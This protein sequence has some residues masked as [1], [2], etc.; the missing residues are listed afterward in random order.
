[1]EKPQLEKLCYSTRQLVAEV[2]RFIKNQ[3]GNVTSDAIETKSRNSLVSHVD[4]TAEERLVSGLNARLDGAVFLTEEG[5]IAPAEGEYQW[6]IDPLD[7]T[8]NFL[9]QLP[10]FS[11]S[12]ALRHENQIILGIVYEVNQ[13][14]CF[15]AYRGGGAWLNDKKIEISSNANFSDALIGTGFPYYDYEHLN[16]YLEVIKQFAKET[17]GIRRFGSAAVDLAY[18]ACGRFDG[19]F[20]YSLNAWD[21]AAGIII[22]EEAGGKISDFQGGKDFLFGKSII[23]GSPVAHDKILS[24]VKAHFKPMTI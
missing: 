6:I 10:I 2:A 12:I 22:V 13:E 24:T 19:F 17:R 14:E 1:M 7:G 23:A 3:V 16:A 8:T 21:V 5:T 9:H 4:K 11:I 15:Y 18:V 20:E